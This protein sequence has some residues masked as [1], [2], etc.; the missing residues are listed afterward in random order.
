MSS[1]RPLG[2]IDILKHMVV[3]GEDGLYVIGC[4]ER[5]I[6]LYS[7]QVRA[8]N[9]IWALADQ[10]KLKNG[11]SVL[12]IGAGAAGL[13]AAAGA[14]KLGAKVKVLERTPQILSF[15]R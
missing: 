7:Q 8:L 11:T 3:P 4:F 9:L 5:R 14:A 15:G 6:T 13:T 12:V 2:S 1:G 10:G